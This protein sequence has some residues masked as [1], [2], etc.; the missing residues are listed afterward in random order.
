MKATVCQDSMGSVHIFKGF[1]N[2]TKIGKYMW[3]HENNEAKV[4][5]QGDDGQ[6]FVDIELS[7]TAQDRLQTNGYVWTE[8]D[9]SFFGE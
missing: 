3:K 7:E 6:V 9:E 5:L 1:I 4:F 8:V 2:P